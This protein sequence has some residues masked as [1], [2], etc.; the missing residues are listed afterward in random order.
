MTLILARASAEF[1]LQVTDRLVSYKQAP[2]DKVANKNIL[3]IAS[4][5]V[6]AIAY[7]GDAYIEEIPTDCWIVENLTGTIADQ[8]HC[9]STHFGATRPRRDIGHSLCILRDELNKRLTQ[10]QYLLI[11]IHGWQWNSK[12]RLRPLVGDITKRKTDQGNL[13]TIYYE[14]RHQYLDGY[15]LT[16]ANPSSNI[17]QKELV[18]LSISLR[19]KTASEAEGLLVDK[20]REI[21]QHNPLVGPHCIS[22]LI[23][24]P[25]NHNITIQYFAADPATLSDP[26]KLSHDEA[27]WA[28]CPWIISPNVCVS[29]GQLS[30][31]GFHIRTGP[32]TI[33]FICETPK[34]PDWLLYHSGQK[35]PKRP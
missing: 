18:D 28:Y 14:P 30:G 20:I 3:Y 25:S 15:P 35:R 24:P 27:M 13:F 29:P 34:H 10:V 26:Q 19:N 4:N 7:S 33:K 11:S 32:F 12:G 1:V 2:F 21:S 23:P 9:Q 17:T 22:I 5:A 8:Q 16:T 6:V 31:G